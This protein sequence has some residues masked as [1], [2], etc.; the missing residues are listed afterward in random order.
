MARAGRALNSSLKPEVLCSIDRKLFPKII[1]G[2]GIPKSADA[3]FILI[4]GRG[5]AIF[6][7]KRVSCGCILVAL[8]AV[9][10][11]D[12]QEGEK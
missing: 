10:C 7:R 1:S 11:I 8:L 2:I 3:L 12:E 5:L 9:E 4:A 6:A